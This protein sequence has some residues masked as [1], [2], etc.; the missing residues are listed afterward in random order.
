VGDF[1]GDT[2]PD[3]AVTDADA[4]NVSVLINNTRR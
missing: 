2:A 3:L 1:N 4:K